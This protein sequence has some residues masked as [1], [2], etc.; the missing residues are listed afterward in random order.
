[1][2]IIMNCIVWCEKIW[3][4]KFLVSILPFVLVY[5]YLCIEIFRFGN[6]RILFLSLMPLDKICDMLIAAQI[7]IRYMD[8]GGALDDISFERDAPYLYRDFSDSTKE[9]LKKLKYAD[10]KIAYRAVRDCRLIWR[11]SEMYQY[12]LELRMERGHCTEKELEYMLDMM[13]AIGI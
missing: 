2:T 4:L 7:T 12:I 10:M 8:Q 13:A 5:I 1:M 9:K 3:F 11:E 6:S